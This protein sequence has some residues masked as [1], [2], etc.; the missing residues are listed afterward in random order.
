MMKNAQTLL[1]QFRS[2]SLSTQEEVLNQLQKEYELQMPIIEKANEEV[3]KIDAR[4]PCPHCKSTN[5][6]K[7]GVQ[8]NV[9]MYSCKDCK[10]WYSQTTGTPLWDIKLKEKWAN[11]LRCMSEGYSLRKSAKEVGIC[12]QT[13][14]DWRHKI[15]ASLD[16]LAPET[17]TGTIECDELELAIN[18]KGDRSLGR[19]SRK[20]STDFSRNE[21]DEISVVQV[22]TAVQREGSKLFKVVETKR[23]SEDNITKALGGKIEGNSILITDKHPS[24]K[25]YGKTQEQITHKTVKA[26]E[27]VNRSDKNVHLQTVNQTHAQLRKFIGKFN[28]VSTKYLQNYLNWYA[29]QGKIQESKSVI[30]TWVLTGMLAP[31]SYQLFWLFKENAVNIRT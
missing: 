29:Y 27:H 16:S 1:E 7:R 14:F 6:Y 23:L 10:K 30:K 2:L 21:G 28:G 4:K 19:E 8:K 24:Y 12:L 25:A 31:L 20:R 18:K 5:I 3:I 17:L 13:S 26:N 11:Y 15:L 9:R 22:V